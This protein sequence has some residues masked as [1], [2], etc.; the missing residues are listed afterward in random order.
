[1]VVCHAGRVF[2]MS[3]VVLLIH[4][5]FLL[6]HAPCSA[7]EPH[8]SKAISFDHDCF[9]INGKDVVLYS[10]SMHYFR[11]A[12]E[13]WKDRLFKMKA[14]GLNAVTCY[15][16]WNY[17]ERV[18]GNVDFS[19]LENFLDLCKELDLYVISRWGPF[20]CGEWDNGGYPEWLLTEGIE[21]SSL[22][23]NEKNYVELVKRWYGD[24]AKVIRPRLITNGGNV[25]LAQVEN[26]YGGGADYKRGVLKTCYQMVRELGID[27]PII[28]CDTDCAWDNDDPV[29]ADIINGNNTGVVRW[30][31]IDR[32]EKRTSQS[33]REE[34][35]GPTIV[36]ENPGGQGMFSNLI[37]LKM[38]A[39]DARDFTAVNKTIWME[40][41][42]LANYY[43][44]YGGTNFEYWGSSYQ[45]T[46]YADRS[47][48]RCPI[49]E[50]GGLD[51]SYYAIKLIG[52]WLKTFGTLEV[53]SRPL[54]NGAAIIDCK[55]KKP[56][57]IVEKI[58]GNAVF[59]FVREQEDKDQQFRISYMDPAIDETITI[60]SK[61]SISLPAREMIILTCN[62]KV[63]ETTMMKYCTSEIL[64]IGN[65]KGK[66]IITVYGPENGSGQVC[67]KFID[68]PQVVGTEDYTW[69]DHAST[70]EINYRHTANPQ[71]ITAGKVVFIAINRELA[72]TTWMA[73]LNNGESVPL[74]SNNYLVKN[75]RA[76]EGFVEIE[77]QT[78][79]GTTH[80]STYLPASPKSVELNGK[81]LDFEYDKSVGKL[82]LNYATPE[83][84]FTE[85]T[86]NEAKFKHE[87][88][89]GIS[90]WRKIDLTQ[91]LQ[92]Q[93]ILGK[94]YVV[95]SAKFED[96]NSQNMVVR[97]YEGSGRTGGA[98]SA[99]L[100]DPVM[101]F[102]NGQYVN[103]TSGYWHYSKIEFNVQKYL[104]KGENHILVVLERMPHASGSGGGGKIGIG[105]PKGLAAVSL[106]GGGNKPWQKMIDGW[107]IKVGIEG[108]DQS[109]FKPEF[110]DREWINV[111]LGNWKNIPE[112]E[113]YNGVCW[114]R[115]SFALD[116]KDEWQIPLYV[117]ANISN[118]ALIYLNGKLIGRYHHVDW[119]REFY[120]PDSWLNRHG[121]NVITIAARN[122]PN[123]AW[124]KI[125]DNAGVNSAAI[126]SYKNC[127]VRTNK[128]KIAF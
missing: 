41:G 40:G 26:E 63:D 38:D 111:P 46:T 31:S 117:E 18:K 39:L 101:V 118:N 23:T 105:E 70:L 2:K 69:N 34:K 126:R 32:V 13:L 108:D 80:L 36:L 122:E 77:S 66:T 72:N 59:L 44:A 7:A 45:S 127:T 30:S 103:K 11:C 20:I 97:F 110:D 96:S 33:R 3:A 58:N 121:L 53:R 29:M 37:N 64:G 102:I 95:Y 120:L 61:E 89:S 82:S 109:Y 60:P 83:Y 125:G 51:E 47:P 50:P 6:T 107:N 113:S 128:L 84:Q 10:G 104:K 71:Y 106:I 75:Q 115:L 73:E 93:G 114:Y 42:S 49:S 81:P 116:L 25:V 79:E 8:L 112:L 55:G 56:P 76:G 124:H 67:L 5:L 91:S 78:F 94:G 52:Q 43:M 54:A 12:P 88:F 19:E 119:Q 24:I 62:I 48:V 85:I 74:I 4:V 98:N 57:K 22:R 14:A 28:T 87:D 1:M 27:V 9:I 65:I 123:E 100:G 99:M 16:P 17:H 86:F 35:N 92:A 90:G 15:F 68:R 21:N